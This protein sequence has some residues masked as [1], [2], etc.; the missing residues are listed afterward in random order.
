MEY[1]KEKDRIHS[2]VIPTVG[3]GWGGGRKTTAMMV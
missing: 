1:K 2:R 3:V